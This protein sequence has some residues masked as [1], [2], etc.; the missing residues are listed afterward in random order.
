MQDSRGYYLG[1]DGCY[2]ARIVANPVSSDYYFSSGDIIENGEIYYFKVEPIRWRILSTDGET[3]FILCD[4]IIE[5]SHYDSTSNNYAESDI[6]AWLNETFY[7]TAFTEFQKAIIL[8]TMVDNSYRSA[9]Y[10][11][12]SSSPCANTNDK[13]FLLSVEEI[14]N[15]EYGILKNKDRMLKASDYSR[16]CGI[17][18]NTDESYYGIGYWWSRSPYRYNGIIAQYVDGGYV[19]YFGYA[20]DNHCVYSSIFGVV[21]ALQIRL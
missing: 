1:N 11:S 6:R 10:S 3:A 16:A 18:M 7:E 4:S 12:V 8:T 21:P 15:S 9:G 17:A 13:I 19:G 20:D 14:E 5:N 2:Y